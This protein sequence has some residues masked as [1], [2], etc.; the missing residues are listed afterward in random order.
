MRIKR[1]M[2]VGKYARSK[3][4]SM[5]TKKLSI[6]I[7]WENGHCRNLA[8]MHTD[9]L[10]HLSALALKYHNENVYVQLEYI[11]KDAKCRSIW[12]CQIFRW[13]KRMTIL[14]IEV[15]MINWTEFDYKIAQSH[16]GNAAKLQRPDWEPAG[17]W[18][19]QFLCWI[20]C[21]HHYNIFMYRKKQRR[22]FI[23]SNRESGVY[24]IITRYVNRK[25]V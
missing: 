10:S 4:L 5:M 13:R 15:L 11:V 24:L 9:L 6:G 23:Q 7:F 2:H 22:L 3:P 1:N 14:Y 25:Y 12:N 21:T 17:S 20:I 16:D 8:R 18:T 19:C